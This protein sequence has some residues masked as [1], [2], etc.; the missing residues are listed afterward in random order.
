MLNWLAPGDLHNLILLLS[1][2]LAPRLEELL[3]LRNCVDSFADFGAFPEC[4]IVR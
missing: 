3:S 1:S 4:H 2:A